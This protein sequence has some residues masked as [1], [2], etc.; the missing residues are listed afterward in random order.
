[1]RSDLFPD[2]V[3]CIGENHGMTWL[4]WQ[5]EPSELC[6]GTGSK[7]WPCTFFPRA[8]KAST[9]RENHEV[10]NWSLYFAESSH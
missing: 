8:Q 7:A 9:G 4:L 3:G 5:L 2:A 10:I 6:R 1:M